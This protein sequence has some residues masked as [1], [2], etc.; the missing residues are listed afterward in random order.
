M[1]V[2]IGKVYGFD[3][4]VDRAKEIV[5]EVADVIGMGMIA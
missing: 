4:G 1:F 3:I 5:G 2:G